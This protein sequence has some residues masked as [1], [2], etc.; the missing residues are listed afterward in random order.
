MKTFGEV[1]QMSSPGGNSAQRVP[2]LWADQHGPRKEKFSHGI[3]LKFHLEE[4]VVSF[5]I[6]MVVIATLFLRPAEMVPELLGLPIYQALIY[7]FKWLSLAF[8]STYTR[9]KQ[10]RNTL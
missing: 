6:F 5:L 1:N 9:L 10:S 2:M 3:L 7:N 4:S 8:F